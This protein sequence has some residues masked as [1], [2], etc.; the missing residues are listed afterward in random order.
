M[1]APLSY[2]SA[3]APYDEH[4]F[5]PK[6]VT[7]TVNVARIQSFLTW[8]LSMSLYGWNRELDRIWELEQNSLQLLNALPSY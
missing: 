8:G 1:S 6:F 3:T 2:S 4:M 7:Q 5:D